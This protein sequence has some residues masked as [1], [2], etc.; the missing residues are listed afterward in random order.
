VLLRAGGLAPVVELHLDLEG[1]RAR[2][3]PELQ[4]GGEERQQAGRPH[5]AVSA[6]AGRRAGVAGA[7]WFCA[8]CVPHS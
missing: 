4:D 5:R 1:V 2:R 7:P 6:G 8:C 3:G